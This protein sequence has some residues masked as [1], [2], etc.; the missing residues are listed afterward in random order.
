MI[1]N[2]PVSEI[3]TTRVKCVG[4]NDYMNKVGEIIETEGVHHV[5]VVE[6]EC[7]VGIISTEDYKML[8]TSMSVFNTL[9]SKME[10]QV[11]LSKVTARDVMTKKVVCVNRD[12]RL[13]EVVQLFQENKF[14]ALPVVDFNRKVIGII[15]TYDLLCFA[16]GKPIIKIE[17]SN[18]N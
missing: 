7:I 11:I 15:T 9:R 17:K 18:Y 4:P 12:T 6:D 1:F 16:F 14:R 2:P 3:M 13:N 10:N 5:P 8:M